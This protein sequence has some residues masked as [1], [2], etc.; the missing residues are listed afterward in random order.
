MATMSP[1]GYIV[2]GLYVPLVLVLY[3]FM[4]P[5]RACI[6]AYV[7]GWL[8]LP[9]GSIHLHGAIDLTKVTMPSFGVLLATFLFNFDR[10]SSF[11]FRVWD[12]P[13][14]A[15]AICP[16]FS[17]MMNHLGIYDAVATITNVWIGVWALPYFLARIYFDDVESLRDLA[18]G[19]VLGGLLYMPLCLWEIR[20]SPQLHYKLYGFVQHDFV[21]T[22]REKGFRPMVFMQHGLALGMFMAMSTVVAAGLWLGQSRVRLFGVTMFWATV[23]LFLTTILC[24]SMGATIWMF[25][26]LAAVIM[27]RTARSPWALIAI[28]LVPP[29]YM[30]TRSVGVFS[31]QSLV[32][33][34]RPFN[35]ERADS[36][37]TRLNNEN[38]F[39]RKA[40]QQPIEG[41]ASTNWFPRDPATGGFIGIPDGMW[42]I[43]LGKHGLI[44]L[45]SLTLAMMIPVW[46]IVR[47]GRG[48]WIWDRFS[49]GGGPGILCLLPSSAKP[50][51]WSGSGTRS[52]NASVPAL[53]SW[54]GRRHWPAWSGFSCLIT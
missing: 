21:Q 41:Y 8:F 4:R 34:I 53:R 35:Q 6:A 23:M 48:F 45:V 31:G 42:V 37:L 9:M 5:H 50:G 29:M 24:K 44:G 11:R 33:L 1:L 3:Q 16:I 47:G 18:L 20:M 10:L 52:P 15:W 22:K 49:N 17:S 19:I 12:I 2:M 25:I 51:Y 14:L 36:L 27:I 38:Q 30:V 43:V 26:G 13:M 40:L 28:M 7:I 54:Y 46:L 32:S 39:V